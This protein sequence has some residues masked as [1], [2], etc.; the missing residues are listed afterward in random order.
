MA[1]VIAVDPYTRLC[2]R[3]QVRQQ[4]LEAQAYR[5]PPASE[6]DRFRRQGQWDMLEELTRFIK[7]NIEKE[8]D[9]G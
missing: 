6:I 5:E 8:Q 1:S 2:H 4:E 7:E 3:I 9:D